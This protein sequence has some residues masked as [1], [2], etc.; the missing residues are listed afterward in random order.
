MLEAVMISAAS[1]TRTARCSI[2]TAAPPNSTS[3]TSRARACGFTFQVQRADFDD[4]LAREA[5]AAGAEIRFEVEITAVDFSGDRAEG[6]QPRRRR[7]STEIHE[8]RFVLDA[9]GFGRTLPKLLDL[10]RPSAFP[11]RAAIFCH[12]QDNIVGGRLRPPED[13]RRHPSRR[14]RDLVVADPVL[15]R[16][17]VGGRRLVDRDSTGHAAARSRSSSGRRMAAEPR[18]HDLLSKARTVRPVGELIG[19]A[20]TRHAPARQT[21]RVAGQAAEFLDPIF[22]SGVTIAMK[23]AILAA[24]VLER[25]FQGESVDWE[26]EFADELNYGVETFRNFVA[27]WYDGSLQDVIFFPRQQPDIRRMIC[28]VLAGYVWDKDNPYTG[29]QSGRRRLRALR[30]RYMSHELRGLDGGGP[31]RAKTCRHDS[32]RDARPAAA[33]AEHRAMRRSGV[34]SIARWGRE[35]CVVSGTARRVEYRLFRQ[36]LSLKCV[37][38]GTETYFVDRRRVTVSDDTFL[39]LNE[40]RIYGSVLEAPTEAYSFSIF[41]RPGFAQEIAADLA[42]IARADARSTTARARGADANSTNALRHHDSRGHSGVAL[43][44]AADRRGRARRKLA[45]G[46]MPVPARATDH[47][48]TGN[49]SRPRR[50]TGAA[51]RPAKRAELLRRLALAID[52][53]QRNLGDAHHAGGH[54]RRRAPVALSFPAPVPGGA[55][56]HARAPICANCAR[57]ARWRCSDRPR[58]AWREIAARVGMSRIAL[59]RSLRA[60]NGRRRARAA[61]AARARPRLHFSAAD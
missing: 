45:R 16:Q 38:R 30:G 27:G 20:A 56:T 51:R 29:P 39:V 59:W 52:F 58:S 8:P 4:T 54:R 46:A 22:S 57:A 19:Y 28:S 32:H 11:A 50:G 36:M 37:A 61:P 53:M 6:D 14:P 47:R 44:P 5:A 60:R 40:G 17:C 33:A 13:P 21:F 9:S 23:S 25:Q 43:H 1:S 48:S 3:P 55:W 24:G 49:A 35:N 18:L 41:F 2:A 31:G 12:V 42:A 34:I 26:R 7:Q 15:E 10:H